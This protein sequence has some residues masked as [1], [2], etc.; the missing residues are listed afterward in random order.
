M[1]TSIPFSI[2]GVVIIKNNINYEVDIKGGNNVM[3]EVYDKYKKK[4][5]FSIEFLAYA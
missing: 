4:K 3:I 2:I 1:K 5:Y